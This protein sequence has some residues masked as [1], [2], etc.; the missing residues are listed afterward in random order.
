MVPDEVFYP[1]LEAGASF[2]FDELNRV[3]A[4]LA[5][6]NVDGLIDAEE[7][8]Q[9]Q[10]G[11]FG[12]EPS[13]IEDMLINLK[14]KVSFADLAARKDVILTTDKGLN[15]VTL[16]HDGVVERIE[17]YR[18]HIANTDY[19]DRGFYWQFI[20]GSSDAERAAYAVKVRFDFLTEL[21]A[22]TREYVGIELEDPFYSSPMSDINGLNIGDE[23]YVKEALESWD[24]NMLD[25]L[26]RIA[27]AFARAA[28]LKNAFKDR[29]VFEG[30]EGDL[31]IY[32]RTNDPI[33]IDDVFGRI[34]SKV[35]II[36]NYTEYTRFGLWNETSY[37]P[38]NEDGNPSV[39]QETDSKSIGTAR[40]GRNYS[41][42]FAYSPLG[43]TDSLRRNL[44]TTG[45]ATLR[46]LH[47]CQRGR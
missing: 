45:S 10:W 24:K 36:F 41:R 28:N 14:D 43:N 8:L 13:T 31:S 18:K 42:M 32:T 35:N 38:L 20:A 5:N 2:E 1:P 16:F 9:L 27:E 12:A 15:A 39:E 21:V 34:P 25:R 30:V 3:K 29:G 22:T 17:I 7:M 44:P 4:T 47:V 23:S 11:D 46:G 40:A 6:R 19:A 37:N 26:E 33:A